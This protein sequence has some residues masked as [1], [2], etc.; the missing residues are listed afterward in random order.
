MQLCNEFG[1]KKDCTIK[2]VH[3]RLSGA[4]RTTKSPSGMQT[5]VNTWHLRCDKHMNKTF[6][7]AIFPQILLVVLHSMLRAI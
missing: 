2:H 6:F 3:G 7:S 1:L 4:G 5:P